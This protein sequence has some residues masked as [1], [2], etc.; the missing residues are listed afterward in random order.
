ML[1]KSQQ[2]PMIMV[3]IC[4]T[5]HLL[6]HPTK[7]PSIL[8]TLLLFVTAIAPSQGQVMENQR[9]KNSAQIGFGAG[10]YDGRQTTGQGG[11]I[12][13]G[14]QRRLKSKRFHFNETLL[15]GMYSSKGIDDARSQWIN[16]ISLQSVLYFDLIRRKQSALVIGAGGLINHSAG[17]LA[18]G[19]QVAGQDR[20][21]Y[22]SLWNAGGCFGIGFRLTPETGRFSFNIMPYSLQLGPKRYLEEF[23]RVNVG[24]SI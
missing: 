22:F 6:M 10:F 24:Y 5:S 8:I 12:A 21:E 15:V 16:S 9:P 20:T 3:F 7:F 4:M 17:L 23:A 2:R 14:F 11:I 1:K 18:P 19:G 13:A